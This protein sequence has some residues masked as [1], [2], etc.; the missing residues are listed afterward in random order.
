[1]KVG[2]IRESPISISIP[3]KRHNVHADGERRGWS[4]GTVAG[5]Q[6]D[7]HDQDIRRHWPPLLAR[8]EEEGEDKE[9]EQG[10]QRANGSK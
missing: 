5:V 4:G 3:G 9:D 8:P 7:L 2:L 10:H 1:M 6:H